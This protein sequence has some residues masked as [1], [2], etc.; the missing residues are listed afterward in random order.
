MQAAD[1]VSGGTQICP[2]CGERCYGIYQK[3]VKNWQ[4]K[5]YSYAYA[6][7]H[8]DGTGSRQRKPRVSWCYVGRPKTDKDEPS[9]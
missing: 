9:D 1:R 4:G 5:T 7:H 3:K 6:A 2:K 8:L